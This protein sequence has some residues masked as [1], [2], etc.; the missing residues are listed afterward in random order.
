M[1]D[2][3]PLLD[4]EMVMAMYRGMIKWQFRRR[5]SPALRTFRQVKVNQ[6]T[7]REERREAHLASNEIDVFHTRSRSISKDL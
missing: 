4:D 5:R 1:K 7:P 3:E 6:D 2:T